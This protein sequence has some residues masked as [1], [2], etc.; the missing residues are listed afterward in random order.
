MI[1]FTQ[2]YTEAC[3]GAGIN[4]TD[5]VNVNY[6][7]R[8]INNGLKLMKA[9]VRRYFTEKWKV[10]D[11]QASQQSYM[12]PADSIRPTTVRIN[13]GSLIFPIGFIESEDG[14]NA[15]NI[16]PQ[17]SVFYPQKAFVRG[18]NEIEVWPIP[19]ELLPGGIILGYEA[20]MTDMYLDD[21]V[22][23]S[24]TVTNASQ[25]ITCASGGFLPTM[26]GMA[27]SVT[28]GTD[29]NWYNILSY[30]NDTTLLLDNYYIGTTT[31]TSSTI[32]GT[33]PDIPEAYHQALEFYALSIFH[34]FKRGNLVKSNEFDGKYQV[35]HDSYVGAYGAKETSL[36]VHPQNDI[37]PYN[38]LLIPPNGTLTG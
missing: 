24:I 17:F 26:V 11:L 19:S 28:D 16:I 27:F 36:V 30:V 18:A 25:T 31:T 20:R 5:T 38:P 10:A 22:G 2:L 9:D 21:T 3:D 23:L 32:I 15:L 13:N 33:V 1:T 4:L 29:G 8:N 12:L 34:M 35:L 37:V 14:W 6:I 7:K